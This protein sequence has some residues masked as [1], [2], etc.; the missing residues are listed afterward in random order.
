MVAKIHR[1]RPAEI[2]T[3]ERNQGRRKSVLET[4]INC[5][6]YGFA[7]VACSERPQYSEAR[8]LYGVWSVPA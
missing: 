1:P 5:G 6:L 3:V 4:V 8:P 7:G 2:R